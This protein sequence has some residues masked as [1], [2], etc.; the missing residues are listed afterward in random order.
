MK[1]K[2]CLLDFFRI[3]TLKDN[4]S[5][6]LCSAYYVT[7]IFVFSAQ[8]VLELPENLDKKRF[9]LENVYIIFNHSSC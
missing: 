4:S 7:V 1:Y 9:H 5:L 8:S 3:V 2:L 6:R